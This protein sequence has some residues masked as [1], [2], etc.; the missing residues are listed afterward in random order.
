MV[1]FRL[2]AATYRLL[3]GACYQATI[4]SMLLHFRILIHF[5]YGPGKYEDDCW[6]GDFRALPGF[7]AAFPSYVTP[8]WERD[9]RVNL[10]KRLAHFTIVRWRDNQPTLN[11]YTVHFAEVLELIQRFEAA[12]PG[13]IGQHFSKSVAFWKS[14]YQEP[15]EY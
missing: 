12:L 3:K 11:Y 7:D 10:N 4:Y 15:V 1:H 8:T 14:Q 9:V 6:V 13:E 2:Y 5:F